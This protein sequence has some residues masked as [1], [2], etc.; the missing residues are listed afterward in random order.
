MTDIPV[1][2]FIIEFLQFMVDQLPIIAA[3]TVA[4]SIPIALAG[5]AGVVS[6][7][8]GVVNIGLE[9]M[10]LTAAFVGWTVGAGAVA[11]MGSGQPTEIF[12]ITMPLLIGLVAALISGMLLALLHAW[13]S[14]SVRA[15]QIISGV[16][17]NIGAIGL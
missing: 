14:V 13:L 10:M 3:A 11:I 2:G 15:D 16:I 12:G 5:L 9:G 6:E 1:L 8:S 17:I 4:A 7:R